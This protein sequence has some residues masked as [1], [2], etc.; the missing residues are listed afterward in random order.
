MDTKKSRK[1]KL[2]KEEGLNKLR[3]FCA[4]RDRCHH[5]VRYKLIEYQIYGDDLEVIMAELIAEDF[6]DEERFTRSY[7][8]G[9]FRIKKWGKNKIIAELKKRQISA[10]CIK[11]AMAMIEDEE[12]QHALHYILSKKVRIS[13]L[14][15]ADARDFQKL[16]RYGISRGYEPGLVQKVGNEI[17]DFA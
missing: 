6:L 13:N 16:Y 10:Y 7:V 17:K 2:T 14:D 11:K 9:K 4:Y 3:K 8:G 5:E 15:M 1:N 12:Y